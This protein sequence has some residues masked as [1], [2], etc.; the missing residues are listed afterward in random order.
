MSESL[1]MRNNKGTR[2]FTY[3]LFKARLC[4]IT[5]T[6]FFYFHLDQNFQQG[7]LPHFVYL[8]YTM[9]NCSIDKRKPHVELLE[10]ITFL[11]SLCLTKKNLLVSCKLKSFMV[12]FSAIISFRR[13][14]GVLEFLV[15][16]NK[17]FME[18]IRLARLQMFQGYYD[19][20]ASGE[21]AEFVIKSLAIQIFCRQ[22]ILTTTPI[23]NILQ[24][25]VLEVVFPSKK[26]FRFPLC[27]QI[28]CLTYIAFIFTT[29][30]FGIDICTQLFTNAI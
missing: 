22:I 9:H 11:I 2:Y 3:H 30:K 5:E 21:F 24:D 15:C 10:K 16:E 4:K 7:L 19:K 27:Y 25:F 13:F 28:L 23:V 20:K 14:F 18:K 17:E 6:I 1:V 29:F 12:R 26:F 8:I